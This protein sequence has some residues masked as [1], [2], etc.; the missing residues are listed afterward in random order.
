MPPQAFKRPSTVSWPTLDS[1]MDWPASTL[2][3]A[4]LPTSSS[5]LAMSAASDCTSPTC[6]A[7]LAP[8]RWVKVPLIAF[9]VYCS[10][11]HTASF[12]LSTTR[13]TGMRTSTCVPSAT[14]TPCLPTRL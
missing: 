11:I 2:T 6:K 9:S 14:I 1:L 4:P 8:L 12:S 10:G 13:N 3:T 7:R 5:A